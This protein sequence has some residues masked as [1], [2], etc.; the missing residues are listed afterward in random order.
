MPEVLSHYVPSFPPVHTNTSQVNSHI[1]V[2]QI[3]PSLSVSHAWCDIHKVYN[4]TDDADTIKLHEHLQFPCS[5]L[6]RLTW[7]RQGVYL[8]RNTC[9]EVLVVVYLQWKKFLLVFF[10]H[11]LL[12]FLMFLFH[13]LLM[14]LQYSEH[15]TCREEEN[16]TYVDDSHCTQCGYNEY[17]HYQVHVKHSIHLTK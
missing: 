15:S 5:E 17:K 13:F 4:W 14:A 2:Y 7:R 11:L 1:G 10:L 16:K 3:A 6:V 8:N 9:S 12:F